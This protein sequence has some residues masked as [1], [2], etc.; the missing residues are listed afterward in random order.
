M[1]YSNVKSLSL[2]K[3]H[4]SIKHILLCLNFFFVYNIQA[5]TKVFLNFEHSFTLLLRI[6]LC[7]IDL[8]IV[9]FH[10]RYSNPSRWTSSRRN[11][12]SP[13]PSKV[14]TPTYSLR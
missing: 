2:I 3:D 1:F 13:T 5:K 12:K 11:L 14:N 4:V 9:Y 10:S 8:L 6:F 7:I